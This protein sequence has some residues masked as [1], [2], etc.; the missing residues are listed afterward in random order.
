[1]PVTETFEVAPA[2]KLVASHRISGVD[3]TEIAK[4]Y[5]IPRGAII[6]A[7]PT[8]AGSAIVYHTN[9]IKEVADLDDDATK[10]QNRTNGSWDAWG[11]GNVAVKTTQQ[12][13]GPLEA[14]ALL[15]SSGVWVIEVSI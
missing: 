8:S 6:K 11:A 12:I 10:V 1:M 9:T 15:V 5:K 4:I 14:V 3:N 13:N 7:Y 2:T